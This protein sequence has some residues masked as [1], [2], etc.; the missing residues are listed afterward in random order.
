M[1]EILCWCLKL[2]SVRR[3]IIEEIMDI[4]ILSKKYIVGDFYSVGYSI[5]NIIIIDLPTKLLRQ[6]RIL[7]GNNFMSK[8][9]GDY[10]ILLT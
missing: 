2:D 1:E 3:T 4:K 5:R 8:F 7:I 9:I 6:T 10:C